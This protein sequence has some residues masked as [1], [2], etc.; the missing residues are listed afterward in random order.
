MWHGRPAR[1]ITQFTFH[2]PQSPKHV[3]IGFALPQS[4]KTPSMQT[5][6]PPIYRRPGPLIG[7]I[8]V[9]L[10]VIIAASIFLPAMNHAKETAHRATCRKTLKALGYAVYWYVNE[11][12]GIC[13]D[14]IETLMLSE[15]I[16]PG[17]FICPSSSDTPAT[18]QTP[19]QTAAALAT[20][21]HCSYIYLAST[22]TRFDDPNIVLLFEPMK[23]HGDGFHAVFADLHV[24]FIT[25]PEA[26]KIQ[27]ELQAH[28]NPPPSRPRISLPA[29][30][31]AEQ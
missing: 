24:E 7:S 20:P 10:A 22:Q 21:G 23:N 29:S 28:Q 30:H 26:P 9:C 15:D 3:A 12:R 5:Q 11:H 14:R 1:E 27:A 8:L 13:P 17:I 2:S 4:S 19:E 31:P 18:G 16:G 25:G 6:N